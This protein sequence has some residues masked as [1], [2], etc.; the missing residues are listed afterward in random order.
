MKDSDLVLIGIG[1]EMG[2]RRATE[3]EVKAYEQSIQSEELTL[4]PAKLAKAI[5]NRKA[6]LKLTEN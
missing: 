1:D 4:D 5:A 6:L 2:W 3:E